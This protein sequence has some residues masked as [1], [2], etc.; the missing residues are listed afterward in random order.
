LNLRFSEKVLPKKN[1]K[2][3]FAYFSDGFILKN[4]NQKKFLIF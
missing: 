1:E 2:G 3:L 4:V